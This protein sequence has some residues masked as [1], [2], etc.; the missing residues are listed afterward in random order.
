MEKLNFIIAENLKKLREEKTLSLNDVSKLT[1]VS[2]SMLGQIERCEVN[3]TVST[4]W[5]IANGLKISCTQL[6]SISEVDFEIVDKSQVHPV[7]EDKGKIRIFP[8]FPFDS[9]TRFETYSIEID[10]RG[11]LSS[12]PHQ[13]G[14]QEFITVF[15]GNITI[16]IDGEDFVITEGNSIRFKADNPHTY[17]NLDDTTCL[18]SMVI[19][20]PV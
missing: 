3:P 9:T 4:I 8:M 10:A 12:D 6:M 13:K 5:K 7:I 20:Y 1:N 19:Y 2:K 15:S 17:K 14:T 11:Y 16:N 18:L